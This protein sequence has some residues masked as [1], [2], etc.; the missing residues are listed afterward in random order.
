MRHSKRF[1]HPRR[2]LQFQQVEDRRVLAGITVG[3]PDTGDSSSDGSAIV[4]GPL[5]TSSPFE[6]VFNL[7]PNIRNNPQAVAG[8]HAAAD[9]IASYIADPVTV[10]LDVDFAGV[11]TNALAGALP[12][13]GLVP[14]TQ[15]RGSIVADAESEPTPA[16]SVDTGVIDDEILRH[17]PEPEALR[18]HLDQGVGFAQ[19]AS[20]GSGSD[21]NF[22]VPFVTPSQGEGG[23]SV[24]R[25]EQKVLG[26]LQPND[27][28]YLE[29]DGSLVFGTSIDFDFDPSNGVDSSSFD[30]RT[31]AIH[32][33][34][35]NLGFV[36]GIDTA[37]DTIAPTVLDLFRFPAH[38][39]LFDPGNTDQFESFTREL[40][41]GVQSMTD[42][43]LPYWNETDVP[44]TG[45]S[46]AVDNIEIV[47]G[48]VF[49]GQQASHW[50]D[51]VRNVGIMNTALGPGVARPLSIP[52]LRALDLLGYDMVNPDF[53]PDLS[54]S[55]DPRLNPLDVNADGDVTAVDALMV[56]NQM[57]VMARG[58]ESLAGTS[59]PPENLDHLD[60]NR[61]GSISAVDVLLVVQELSRQSRSSLGGERIGSNPTD[62]VFASGAWQLQWADSIED[63]IDP[64]AANDP[65][66]STF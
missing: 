29:S 21:S 19:I 11:P 48:D 41:P 16:G 22:D 63:A 7:G 43:V 10:F 51:T 38:V 20:D 12:N 17:L 18:F 61:D 47:M 9:E 13:S 14:Y 35:H 26:I 46:D 4:S 57:N 15:L 25:A 27:P 56:V 44:D 40:R 52:D 8:L 55:T 32:E 37:G 58:G 24:T 34:F 28:S 39:G 53:A 42:F 66:I 36:S 54:G 6:I 3:V 49:G 30:F 33:I 1:H 2:P 62:Q 45:T 64:D 59:S 60:V 23:I 31:V 5:G 65:T 50:N